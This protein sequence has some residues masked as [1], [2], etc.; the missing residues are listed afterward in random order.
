MGLRDQRTVRPNPARSGQSSFRYEWFNIG[1]KKDF[2]TDNY[3]VAPG[4][5][6]VGGGNIKVEI[7]GSYQ[8]KPVK[9][10]DGVGWVTKPVKWHNGTTWVATTN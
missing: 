10:H 7:S 8:V 5:P 9:W 3:F 1:P 4:P 2:L 6:P